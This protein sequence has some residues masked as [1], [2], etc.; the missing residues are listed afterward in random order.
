MGVGSEYFQAKLD[1]IKYGDEALHG[2]N[3]SNKVK[4]EKELLRGIH[5]D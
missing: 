1:L 2:N 3:N 5:G 4:S